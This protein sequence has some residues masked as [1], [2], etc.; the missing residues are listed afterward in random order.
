MASSRPSAGRG[1]LSALAGAVFAAAVCAALTLAPGAPAASSCLGKKATIVRGG[2]NDTIQGT[3][4]HDVIVSGGGNDKIDGMGGNDRICGGP[5]DDTL[6]GGKGVDRLDGGGGNDTITGDNGPD[7]LAGGPGDDYLNG[8][9]G[10]DELDGGGGNDDVLGDKGNDVVK[11]GPGDDAVNAGLGDDRGVSGGSGVDVVIAGNGT[12]EASGGPGDG[13]IVRGDAGNDALDGGPGSRDII[14]FESATKGPVTVDLGAGSAKGD[15]H[16]K[17]RGFE[18]AVGSPYNDMV[19]GDGGPNRLDGGLGDDILTGRGGGDSAF[20]GPGNDTC[21]DFVATNS[22][23]LETPPPTNSTYVVLYDGIAGVSL[24]VRGTAG[25]NGIQIR[26]NGDRLF[27]TDTSPGGVS[28]D[29]GCT[30]EAQIVQCES[31]GKLNLIAVLGGDGNDRIEVDYSIPPSTIVHANGNNGSDVL[32]G[33]A[34]DDVLEAGENYG[35][36]DFGNDT[37]IGNAGGDALYADPGAD[38]L[39]GGN[40]NDLMVSSTVTCQ[41]HRFN[42]GGGEDTASY[43]RTDAGPMRMQLAGTGGPVSGCANLDRISG[44]ADGFEGS[45]G[46]DILIGDGGKNSFFGQGGADTFLGKGGQDFIDATDGERD[47]R[48]DCGPGRNEGYTSDRQDPAPISC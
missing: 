4:A 44:S 11:G 15:G 18:D 45:Q 28:V 19:S 3:K 47:K 14:S 17:L 25:D 13:D 43:A 2:G 5:G 8:I 37:L 31:R 24:N 35:R 12:D 38:V 21:N 23:G 22:C 39:M 29:T 27:V 41:G 30:V 7:T 20:G 16:D 48:L 34:G 46:P 42:G 26:R 36:S 9:K 32:S 6:V 1:K 40:G 10:S 33:G